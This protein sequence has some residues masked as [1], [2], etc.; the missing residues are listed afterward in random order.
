M[1]IY[2]NF[3]FKYNNFIKMCGGKFDMQHKLWYVNNT[4]QMDR[5][6][7]M[8]EKKETFYICKIKDDAYE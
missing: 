1:K 6:K 5:I 4:D 3:P 2:V 7:E 8:I